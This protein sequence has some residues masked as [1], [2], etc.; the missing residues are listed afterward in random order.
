MY[1]FF[2]WYFVPH[3]WMK[4]TGFYNEFIN[5]LTSLI[6][7]VGIGL[8]HSICYLWHLKYIYSTS[9]CTEVNENKI[10]YLI[11]MF[12]SCS[13][14]GNFYMEIVKNIFHIQKVSIFISIFHYILFLLVSTYFCVTCSHFFRRKYIHLH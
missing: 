7:T 1:N 10:A 6:F 8:V 4:N 3:T 9:I 2:H 11:A 5:F 13:V 14:M 12:S